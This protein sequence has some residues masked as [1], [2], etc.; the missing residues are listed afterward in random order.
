VV[1]SATTNDKEIARQTLSPGGW[2]RDGPAFFVAPPRR[3]TAA[4][5]ALSLRKIRAVALVTNIIVFMNWN[6]KYTMIATVLNP[7]TLHRLQPLLPGLRW[8]SLQNKLTGYLKQTPH[9]GSCPES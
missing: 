4:P 2:R 3:C 7:L 6:T 9:S 5:P 8:R 1:T